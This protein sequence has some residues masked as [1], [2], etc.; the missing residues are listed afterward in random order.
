MTEKQTER[1]IRDVRSAFIARCDLPSYDNYVA[2]L[3]ANIRCNA[4]DA[5]LIGDHETCPCGGDFIEMKT[6]TE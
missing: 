1:L 2:N 4:C 5:V 3:R 6:E